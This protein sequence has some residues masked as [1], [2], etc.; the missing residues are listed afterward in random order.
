M[1]SVNIVFVKYG[2][3]LAYNIYTG[4]YVRYGKKIKTRDKQ[5]NKSYYNLKAVNL[6]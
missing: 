3:I 1:N 4:N 5:L 6:N 2:S